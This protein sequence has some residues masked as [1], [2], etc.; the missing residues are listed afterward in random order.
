M[1]RAQRSRL[2]HARAQFFT[3]DRQQTQVWRREVEVQVELMTEKEREGKIASQ[4][5]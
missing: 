4:V 2:D 3:R 5:K 1:W